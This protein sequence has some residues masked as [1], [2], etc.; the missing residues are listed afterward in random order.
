MKLVNTQA[1]TNQS[2]KIKVGNICKAALKMKNNTYG[3]SAQGD[4]IESS[5]E[6]SNSWKMR[7]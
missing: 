5:N 1:I 2:K 6:E 7:K 4:S 3:E